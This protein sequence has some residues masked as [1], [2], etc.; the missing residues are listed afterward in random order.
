MDFQ[1]LV[2]AQANDPKLS[3]MQVDLSF[4]FSVF[5]FCPKQL[6]SSVIHPLRYK[7]LTFRSILASSANDLR[8]I[9]CCHSP[10]HIF[11]T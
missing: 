11:Y 6:R 8:F 5:P 4:N 2:F 3:Q 1:E 10:W 7:I 9:S